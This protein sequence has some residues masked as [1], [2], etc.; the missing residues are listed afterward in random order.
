AISLAC[1]DEETS[2]DLFTT[3]TE[4]EKVKADVSADGIKTWVHF[5][6]LSL[7]HFGRSGTLSHWKIAKVFEAAY[8]Y[9]LDAGAMGYTALDRQQHGLIF[10]GSVFEYDPTLWAIPAGT[11]RKN[12]IENGRFSTVVRLSGH[13]RFTTVVR[14]SGH[15]RFT[16]VVRLP[17]HARLTTVARLS[18]HGRFT[19][20]VRL[21][22]HG[23]FTTVV[24]LPGH[25]RLTTV[26]RLS[27]H[28]RFTTVVQ[29]SGH[30]RLTT[31]V[32]LSGHGRITTVVRLSGH[33]PFTT[34]V[35]VEI[36]ARKS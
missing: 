1:L 13:G 12:V 30:G 17:G 29:L 18:G 34:V 7:D 11:H 4:L 35:E 26:A 24:R 36:R 3:M 27:G 14:L 15:G 28:S 5:S 10:L 20:V 32:R 22:G 21:S 8:I 23:R 19:T 31:M 33:A 16:T 9:S 25:A 2:E 6:H